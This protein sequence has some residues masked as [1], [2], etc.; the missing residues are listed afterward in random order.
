MTL[1]GRQTELAQ[2]GG[3]AAILRYPCPGIDEEV[4]EE[5][6]EAGDDDQEMGTEFFHGNGVMVQGRDGTETPAPR[7]A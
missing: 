7:D 5:E 6:D 3:V 1:V 4:E 2:L